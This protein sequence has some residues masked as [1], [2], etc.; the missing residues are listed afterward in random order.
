MSFIRHYG[1]KSQSEYTFT[2]THFLPYLQEA[3]EQD[4]VTD[5][6]SAIVLREKNHLT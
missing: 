2:C 4:R 5:W 1:S 3:I 6:K